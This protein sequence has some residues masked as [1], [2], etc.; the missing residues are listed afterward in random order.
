MLLMPIDIMAVLTVRAGEPLCWD[1]R[2]RSDVICGASSVSP[3]MPS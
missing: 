2:A 1:R 3:S